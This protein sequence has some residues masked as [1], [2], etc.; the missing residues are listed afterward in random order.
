MAALLLACLWGVVTLHRKS[1]VAGLAAMLAL[2]LAGSADAQSLPQF[3]A[4]AVISVP[5]GGQY[6]PPGTLYDNYQN[7]GVTSLASQNSSSTLTARSADD[8]RIA[9]GSCMSG[10]FEVSRIRLQ[11]VQS[12]TAVQ[13][14]ALELYDDGGSGNAPVAGIT[15]FAS[16]A[17]S[18]RSLLGPFGVGTTVFEVS[19][20][21]PGLLINGNT[22]YW[23]SGFGATAAANT[24][25]F[26][27]FFATSAG[28]AGTTANAV[29]IAPN[30]GV[31]AWTPVHQVIGGAPVAL[32]FAVDGTCHLLPA[33]LAI[34]KTNGVAALV[35]GT[36]V[37]Y[38]L[39]ASNAGPAPAMGA[40]VSDALP[41][42][43]A[44]CTWTCAGTGG[45]SCTA[46]GVGS[47]GDSVDLPVG[48]ALTYL[49]SCGIPASAVGSISNSAAISAPAAMIDPNPGNN[50]A[51]DTDPLTPQADLAMALVAAPEP[52]IAGTQ[53]SYSA[54]LSNDGP[55]DAIGATIS[56]PL[57]AHTSLVSA[58]V[59]GGGSC[60]GSPVVCTVPG[61]L[62]PG[63]SRVATVVL[64][65]A[66]G[67]A[68]AGNIVG[69]A[70]GAAT[71]PDPNSGNNTASVS[72]QVLGQAD[73]Q[74]TLVGSAQQ[75]LVGVPL[76][77]TASSL[78]LGPSDALDMAIALTLSP[79]LRYGGHEADLGATCAV[80]QVGSSGVIRC[81]WAGAMAPGAT[82]V[83]Q[84]V[85]SSRVESVSG[86]MGSTDSL[87]AD[88]VSG[89]NFGQVSV[90]VG[91]LVE[92][93]PALGRF[94]L[95]LGVV[96]LGLV[97]VVAAR[98]GR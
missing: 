90:Q 8:F 77:F 89:N 25:G 60:G 74:L 38:T 78:N 1:A 47:I 14:F 7:D 18:S 23:L 29:I 91:Y 94:G 69:M 57:P 13:P 2:S 35:P 5:A 20:Q 70:S 11:L 75:V 30:S 50:S 43:L 64:A 26:N 83:L 71:T 72:T 61:A 3:R 85:A 37:V 81:T 22:T 56:L 17:E 44:G 73:L 31:A 95:V 52:V 42:P 92:G 66:P 46:I 40:T 49:V 98:S 45:G 63:D 59:A 55:S 19:F 84:V 41:P 15:P 51:V 76:N 12:D 9:T 80:P 4:N 67:A 58:S 82:R 24:A 16:F 36:P 79:D 6:V 96:L 97:G 28:A 53:L 34:T 27:N 10:Q 87:T 48:G 88:P 65:V 68:A 62:A 21:T 39:V 86:A 54:T 93:I 32:S 33:D